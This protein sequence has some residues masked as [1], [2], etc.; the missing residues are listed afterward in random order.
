MRE[1]D[2]SDPVAIYSAANITEG[3]LNQ[4]IGE[5]GSGVAPF[6]K[7]W[8]ISGCQIIDETDNWIEVKVD[9]YDDM[10]CFRGDEELREQWNTVVAVL[11]EEPKTCIGIECGK[12]RSWTRS[13]EMLADEFASL[14]VLKWPQSCLYDCIDT[15]TSPELLRAKASELIQ[16]GTE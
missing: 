10:E 5:L 15:V 8:R 4:F 11:G 6:P 9:S 1:N 14:F 12:A 7:G 13:G 16:G 3:E 2:M